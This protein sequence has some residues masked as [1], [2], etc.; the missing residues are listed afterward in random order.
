MN[1]TSG[2]E[3]NYEIPPS[4]RAKMS[5]AQKGKIISEDSKKKISEK[6]KSMPRPR[7]Y[8]KDGVNKFYREQPPE[9]WVPGR[10]GLKNDWNRGKRRWFTNGLEEKWAHECPDGWKPG[11]TPGKK[12]KVS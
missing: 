3:G 8:N 4:V 6:I 9:G 2:G 5:A 10:V 1:L 12:R 11:R 7:W